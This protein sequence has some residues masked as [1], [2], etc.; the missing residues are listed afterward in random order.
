VECVVRRARVPECAQVT[1]P[2]LFFF[3]GVCGVLSVL[4][5]SVSLSESVD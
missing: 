2:I 5:A 3:A 4:L 1:D